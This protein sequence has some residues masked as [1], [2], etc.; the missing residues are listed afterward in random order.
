MNPVIVILRFF[1]HIPTFWL[2]YASISE[3]RTVR[4][5]PDLISIAPESHLQL[6]LHIPAIAVSLLQSGV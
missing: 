4:R 1:G 2:M 5:Y 3:Y 6:S